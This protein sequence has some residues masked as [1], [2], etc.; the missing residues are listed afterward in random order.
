MRSAMGPATHHGTC[1]D[2][3]NTPA[4]SKRLVS[5]IVVLENAKG[6]GETCTALA[7]A[8]SLPIYR[9]HHTAC[10]CSTRMKRSQ[11]TLTP[12]EGLNHERG[13]QKEPCIFSAIHRRQLLRSM[14]ATVF[15][16][17]LGRRRSRVGHS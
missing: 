10:S 3:G 14:L 17:K 4:A 2:H 15:E 11:S 9:M 12:D 1:T 6:E 7:K 16:L 8:V 5:R 13:G